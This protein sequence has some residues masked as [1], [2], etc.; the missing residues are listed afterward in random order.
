MAV[1]RAP[2]P[3]PGQPAE[4][5]AERPADGVTSMPPTLA[6]RCSHSHMRRARSRQ[7]CAHF[8]VRVGAGWPLTPSE[9]SLRWSGG[10]RIVPIPCGERL[11]RVTPSAQAGCS[12]AAG[13]A[14]RKKTRQ[15]ARAVHSPVSSCVESAARLVHG[16]VRLD[17]AHLLVGTQY[18]PKVE[19]SHAS[20]WGPP[21][22]SLRQ[23]LLFGRSITSALRRQQKRPQGPS[24]T[25][26]LPS[27][28]VRV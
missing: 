4:R 19:T 14:C 5:P 11:A 13:E 26:P 2:G 25:P 22:G 7:V 23:R 12:L 6:N 24:G 15:A 20:G 18:P 1:E 27:V 28:R 8:N 16:E 3:G 9:V 10:L 17:V 21:N